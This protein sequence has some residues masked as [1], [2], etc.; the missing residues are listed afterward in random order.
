MKQN[1]KN[2]NTIDILKRIEKRGEEAAIDIND[3]KYD[4]KDLKLRFH[5]VEHNTSLIKADIQ[6]LRTE[7]EEIKGEIGEVKDELK[8]T[9]NRLNIRITTVGDLITVDLGKKITGH[10]KRIS[11]LEQNRLVA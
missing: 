3:L 1:Q 7:M 11:R 5:G 4:L 9:E 6:K 8:S 10:E 2:E